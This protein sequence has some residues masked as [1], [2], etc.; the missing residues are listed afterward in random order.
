MY[1]CA[2]RGI[3]V[4]IMTMVRAGRSGDR[5]PAAA[6]RGFHVLQIVPRG[7]GAKERSERERCGGRSTMK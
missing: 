2:S 3:S 4:G 6:A 7:S 5:I 1:Y